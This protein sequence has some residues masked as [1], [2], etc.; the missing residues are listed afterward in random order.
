LILIAAY[1]GVPLDFRTNP[2]TINYTDPANI[3]AIRQVLDLAKQGYIQYQELGSLGNSE[4]NSPS[5]SKPAITDGYLSSLGDPGFNDPSQDTYKPVAYPHGTQY[6]GITYGVTFAAISATSKNPDAC[7]RWISTLA[8]HPE[9][10]SGM[11]ARRSLINDPALS[12]SQGK[13]IV[14]MYNAVDT[15]LRNS[16]TLVFPDQIGN[17]D[18]TS[19]LLQHWLYEAFDSYVLHKGDLDSALK[20][21]ELFAKG[22]QDCAKTLPPYDPSSQ[23][24]SNAYYKAFAACASKID[25]RLSS[26][27]QPKG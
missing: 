7:Y 8:K 10:F 19:F 12:A 4:V 21:A 3:A 5:V 27:F 23:D 13:E 11:P 18:P 20:D 6:A 22:F 24:S 15:Q 1:G 2:V 14:A 26:M 25:S 9:L 17:N 16:N